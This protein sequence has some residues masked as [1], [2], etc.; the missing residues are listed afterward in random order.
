MDAESIKTDIRDYIATVTIDRPPVNAMNRQ[1][2]DEI[3]ASFDALNNRPDVRVAIFTG[4]G[5][6]FCAGADMKAR[7]RSLDDGAQQP[8]H[9]AMWAHSR[10]AREAFHSILECSVP[11]IGA[12][13]GPALGG[14]L[15]LV[16][17]CDMLI[18][19]ER[20]LIGLP[21]I[22]VGLLGGGR[23]TQRLFG[24]YKARKM[25]YTG[26]RI[27]AQELYRRGIVEKVVPPERLMDE[28]R[29]QAQVIADKSPLAIRLAKHAMN[30]I[31]FMDLRDGYRFE[32]NMTHELT[33]S[34]DAKEAARAFVEKRKPVFTGQ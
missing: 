10:A 2:F 25:M 4:A 7:S 9:G 8:R 28:A 6:C 31:E 14:G 27:G 29:A 1:M 30:A 19:S 22:D 11:V 34:D 16:A 13:N 33:G 15:A 23:H 20:A 3:Q 18:A 12:I 26:E 17:S 32:Q 24:V 5:K 21:E